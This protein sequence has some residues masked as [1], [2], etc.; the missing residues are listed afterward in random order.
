MREIARGLHKAEFGSI[1]HIATTRWRLHQEP[2]VITDDAE[3]KIAMAN[4]LP[5]PVRLLLA[6][7]FKSAHVELVKETEKYCVSNSLV[8]PDRVRDLTVDRAGMRAM[9]GVFGDTLFGHG[10]QRAGELAIGWKMLICQL[11]QPATFHEVMPLLTWMMDHAIFEA[12]I[13]AKAARDRL[14][15]WWHATAGEFKD[16]EDNSIFQLAFTEEAFGVIATA[17]DDGE[18]CVAASS[19]SSIFR[20]AANKPTMEQIQGPSVVVMRGKHAEE[21]GLPAAWKEMRDKPLPLVVARDVHLIRAALEIEFPHAEQAIALLTRDL[22]D[23]QPV[24]MRPMIL[25]GD[26]GG[27]KSRLVRKLAD[28]LGLYVYRHDGASS[29]DG[30]FS[31]TTK[32]WSSAQPSTPARAI[33]MSQ[34]ANPILMVDEIEKAGSSTYNGNLWFSMMPFLERETAARYRDVGIDAELDLSNISHIATA[35]SI[36]PLPGPLRDRFRVVRISRPTLAHLPTLAEQVMRDLAGEDDARQ[37]DDPLALD[38]LEIIGRAWRQ[39]QFSLRK[40]HRIVAATLEAR[41]HFAAR[42]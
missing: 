26:P 3:T 11:E 17:R 15:V 18:K 24:R 20:R 39:E 7:S 9:A 8:M 30:T 34:T 13:D 27:G 10:D 41:D 29:R 5:V 2:H 28:Q 1:F 25:V 23:G 6:D 21:R 12:D 4:E 19:L 31:G 33:M 32:S 16:S 36:D 35:N 38:E 14:N 42:H 22:R 37:F 40:L